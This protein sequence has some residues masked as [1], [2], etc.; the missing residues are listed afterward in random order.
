MLN[1]S[2]DH[3]LC[4]LGPEAEGGVQRRQAEAGPQEPGALPQ[5]AQGF[6][7]LMDLKFLQGLAAPGEAVGVLA[8]QSV[9]EPS[10]Q[11]T[12][13]TFHMAGAPPLKGPSLSCTVPLYV[14]IRAKF[15]FCCVGL[16]RICLKLRS[17]DNILAHLAI[18][19]LPLSASVGMVLRGGALTAALRVQGA[20]RPT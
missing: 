14:E 7:R 10:T 9:G 2:N 3:P 16:S 1:D 12:L 13:N 17:Y 19:H 18:Q 4:R 20:G 8:A 15:S 5:G 11:M 6:A